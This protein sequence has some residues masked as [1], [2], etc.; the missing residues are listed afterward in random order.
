MYIWSLS[1][2]LAQTSKIGISLGIFCVESIKSV[3]CCVNVTS[4]QHLRKETMLETQSCDYNFEFHPGLRA[5]QRGWSMS[6]ISS[7]QC[8]VKWAY[9]MKWLKKPRRPGFR[10]LP[11]E[12][13][14]PGGVLHLERTWMPQPTL[15]PSF[16]AVW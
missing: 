12:D 11:G 3:F 8:L 7:G 1:P 14:G 13:G 15:H 2:L 9:I 10:E 6:L 4:G 5:G 16:R